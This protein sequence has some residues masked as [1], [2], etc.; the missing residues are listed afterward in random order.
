MLL[1]CAIPPLDGEDKECP[2]AR[3]LVCEDNRCVPGEDAGRDATPDVPGIDAPGV[4]APVDAVVDSRRPDTDIAD[5]D[6]DVDES[7]DEGCPF[8]GVWCSSFEEASAPYSTGGGGTFEVRDPGYMSEATGFFETAS[9]AVYLD[10][11]PLPVIPQEVHARMW[12][13]SEPSSFAM[14]VLVFGLYVPG[15]VEG[16]GVFL[17]RNLSTGVMSVDFESSSGDAVATAT[18]E[19]FTDWACVRLHATPTQISMRVNDGPESSTT[20]SLPDDRWAGF[21]IGLL[22]EGLAG[23]GLSV[24]EVVVGPNP[25]PCEL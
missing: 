22:Q 25:I 12:L 14:K 4:D 15:E 19:P 16:V 2:C 23:S 20:I 1:S 21:A 13:R 11:D 9:V 10:P 18:Y 6:L 3:G 7:V 24:D 17:Q 5:A 8:G